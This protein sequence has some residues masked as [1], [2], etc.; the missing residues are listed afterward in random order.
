M[1]KSLAALLR[2]EHCE[3]LIIQSSQEIAVKIAEATKDGKI[4]CIFG[5]GGSA[6]DSQHWAFELVC[7][8]CSKVRAPIPALALTTDSSVLTAWSNDFDFSKVFSRQIEAFSNQIGVSIGLSTSGQSSNVLDA[9]MC[10][11]ALGHQTILISGEHSPTYSFVQYH[12]QLPSSSTP[13]I[14]TMTQ[15]LYHYVCEFLD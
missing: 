4:V 2:D 14:Q 5:N 8:Y 3:S 12:V 11:N 7:T 6:A 10:S 13:V 9:L 15:L 1:L